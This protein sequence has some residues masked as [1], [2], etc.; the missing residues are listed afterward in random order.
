MLYVNGGMADDTSV[1]R[2][3]IKEATGASDQM[4]TEFYDTETTGSFGKTLKKEN[5]DNADHFGCTKTSD[6]GACSTFELAALQ[7]GQSAI[8]SNPR[9]PSTGGTNFM[10]QSSTYYA[11]SNESNWP[12]AGVYEP[13]EYAFYTQPGYWTSDD[14]TSTGS[15]PPTLTY[16]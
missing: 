16:E 6:D 9:Y 13:M 8:T 12:I 1:Y 15:A 5:K 2:A 11:W 14:T 4:V 3:Q 10:P 7:W